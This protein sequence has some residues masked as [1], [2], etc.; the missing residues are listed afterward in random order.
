MGPEAN[1]ETTFKGAINLLALCKAWIKGN[2]LFMAAIRKGDAVTAPA[3]PDFGDYYAWCVELGIGLK[4]M[5]DAF[6]PAARAAIAGWALAELKRW[7]SESG[8][9][10]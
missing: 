8:A 10:S 2:G 1:S 9:K 4:P 3:D 7:L 6:G 5:W